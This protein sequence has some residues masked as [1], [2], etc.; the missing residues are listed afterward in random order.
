MAKSALAKRP[1]PKLAR[2][3]A[4]RPVV[5]VPLL[6]EPEEG[7]PEDLITT[8]QEHLSQMTDPR[9]R[10]AIQTIKSLIR[11]EVSRESPCFPLIR[12]YSEALKGAIA[13][14][15]VLSVDQVDIGEDRH[16]KMAYGENDMMID[17]SPALGR[18]PRVAVPKHE[19]LQDQMLGAIHTITKRLD[20]ISPQ[21]KAKK[22][23]SKKKAA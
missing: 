14:A 21:R 20:K 3:P 5:E 22:T 12:L 17:V 1:S 16:K 7:Y 11:I 18:G 15:G 6:G 13:R 8:K 9:D 23:A 10:R 4:A 2:R 19:S